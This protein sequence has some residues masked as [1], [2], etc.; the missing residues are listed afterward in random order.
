MMAMM[1]SVVLPLLIQCTCAMAAVTAGATMRGT[2]DD[3]RY[4]ETVIVQRLADNDAGG[5]ALVFRQ[6]VASSGNQPYPTDTLDFLIS[7]AANATSE[8]NRQQ[9]S[10]NT[11]VQFLALS[12]AINQTALSGRLAYAF[13]NKLHDSITTFA[14]PYSAED[15]LFLSLAAGLTQAVYEAIA[16][17]SCHAV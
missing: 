4:N 10:T 17:V 8:G 11:A 3:A 13:Q 9:P 7:A 15:I 5:A 1:W 14:S 12:K 2:V 6:K 16:T